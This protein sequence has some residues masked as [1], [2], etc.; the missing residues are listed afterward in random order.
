[1]CL[2]TPIYYN[3]ILYVASIN[4][5]LAINATN[6]S[7]IWSAPIAKSP[8]SA[9]SPLISADNIIYLASGNIVYAFTLNGTQIWNYTLTGKYGDLSSLSSPVLSNDEALSDLVLIF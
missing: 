7:I 4:R 1:M 3:G 9:S 8:T 5:L 2:G 6:S